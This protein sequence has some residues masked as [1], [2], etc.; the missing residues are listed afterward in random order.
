M[1]MLPDG[2]ILDLKFE[3]RKGP[4]QLGPKISG[5]LDEAISEGFYDFEVSHIEN[6]LKF[7]DEDEE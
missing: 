2:K 6:N 5:I 4:I 3:A 1:P 7:E